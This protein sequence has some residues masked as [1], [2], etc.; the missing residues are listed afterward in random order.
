MSGAAEVRAEALVQEVRS[1][2]RRQ[3]RGNFVSIAIYEVDVCGVIEHGKRMLKTKNEPNCAL[4]GT[5]L[6]HYASAKRGCQNHSRSLSPPRLYHL[7]HP[8]YHGGFSTQAL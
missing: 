5:P 4:L 1:K 6:H 3:D 7:D 8:T 2:V